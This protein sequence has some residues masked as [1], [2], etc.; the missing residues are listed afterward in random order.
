MGLFFSMN[1]LLMLYAL[2]FLGGAL[3]PEGAVCGVEPDVRCAE[4][5]SGKRSEVCSP[6]FPCSAVLERSD[7]AEVKDC[8]GLAGAETVAASATPFEITLS[9]A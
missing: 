9:W 7:S 2:N 8:G 3:V 5:T 4:A 1:F 6:S